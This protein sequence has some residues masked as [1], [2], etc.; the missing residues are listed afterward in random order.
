MLAPSGAQ[1][2]F[3][4]GTMSTS[5]SP[6]T[7]VGSLPSGAAVC[8]V[9]SI[10][11]VLTKAMRLP[12]GDHANQLIASPILVRPEPSDPT[13]YSTSLKTLKPSPGSVA[14]NAR[15]RPSGDH[16]G[17]LPLTPRDGATLFTSDPSGA[18]VKMP[19]LPTGASSPSGSEFTRFDVKAMR[20]PSGDHTGLR[21][22]IP[23]FPVFVTLRSSDP[24]SA[25]V[26]ISHWWS[27]SHGSHVLCSNA[28]NAIRDPSG[29]MLG[30][31]ARE[32][33]RSPIH[34]RIGCSCDPSAV[35]V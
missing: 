24:S 33:R 14:T 3:P 11:S 18:I 27:L 13:T 22:R 20:V 15:L 8:N 31:C 6:S 32:L 10:S 16:T 35:T 1:D 5:L 19:Y 26:T 4:N 12:S 30:D 9:T 21:F 29:E 17:L 23:L 2:R 34:S 25:D 7:L 28:V